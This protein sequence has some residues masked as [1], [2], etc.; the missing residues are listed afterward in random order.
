MNF[1]DQMQAFQSTLHHR[2][3]A[4]GCAPGLSAG[5]HSVPW[6]I[7]ATWIEKIVFYPIVF[8]IAI[9]YWAVYALPLL[10]AGP[11]MWLTPLTHDA[12]M[13]SWFLFFRSIFICQ[14]L[15]CPTLKK[16]RMSV[17]VPSDWRGLHCRS[18]DEERTP[19]PS[20][21]SILYNLELTLAGID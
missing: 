11:C 5:T 10:R 1:R 18:C 2:R 8:T 13:M 19:C 16:A 15:S 21:D 14:G 3:A 17:I 6:A 4:L 7:R 9:S 20:N 12:L